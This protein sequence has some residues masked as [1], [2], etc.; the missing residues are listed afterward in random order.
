MLA[1]TYLRRMTAIECHNDAVGLAMVEKANVG[2]I[3]R[4]TSIRFVQIKQEF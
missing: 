3:H 1:D 4:Q 2:M